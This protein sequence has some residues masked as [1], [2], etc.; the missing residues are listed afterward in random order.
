MRA[1]RASRVIK[2]AAQGLREREVEGVPGTDPVSQLQARDTR[3]RC[4]KRSPGRTS[5]LSA[6]LGTQVMTLSEALYA[7]D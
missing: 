6:A 3:A 1:R 4:P 2:R 5:R 7:G